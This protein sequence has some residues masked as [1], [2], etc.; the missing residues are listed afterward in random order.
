MPTVVGKQCRNRHR[1]KQDDPGEEQ[2][3]RPFSNGQR[4]A[5]CPF[6]EASSSS[7]ED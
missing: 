1:T 3:P 7:V 6:K 5:Q 2:P 4:A